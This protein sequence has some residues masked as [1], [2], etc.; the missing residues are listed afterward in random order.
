MQNTD[1]CPCRRRSVCLNSWNTPNTHD[2]SSP[3]TLPFSLDSYQSE[4]I[5][6]TVSPQLLHS[7][8]SYHCATPLATSSELQYTDEFKMIAEAHLVYP[9]ETHSVSSPRPT[10]RRRTRTSAYKPAAPHRASRSNRN[11]KRSASSQPS[12]MGHDVADG[13]HVIRTRARRSKGKGTPNYNSVNESG[14]FCCETCGY[15]CKPARK[16]DF[17]RHVNTHYPKMVN[18]PVICCGVPVEHRNDSQW[19]IPANAPI[20]TFYGRQM[21]GGCGRIFSRTDALKRHLELRGHRCAG[22][23]KGEWHPQKQ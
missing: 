8:A 12:A 19:K 18:G 17:K 4:P 5:P 7:P 6:L 23:L 3:S 10:Q 16:V 11:T 14:D 1:I 2:L 20:M 22:D 9:A 15:V 21:V 13:E